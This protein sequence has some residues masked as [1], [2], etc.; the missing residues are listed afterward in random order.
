MAGG[1]AALAVIAATF[2]G[3][4]AAGADLGTIAATTRRGFETVVA[5]LEEAKDAPTTCRVVEGVVA[6][7]VIAASVVER[8]G[9][10]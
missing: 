5:A 2:R 3:V 6:T 8:A 9:I 7:T 1:G 10:V 4:E